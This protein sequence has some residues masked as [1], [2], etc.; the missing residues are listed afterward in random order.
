MDAQ[1]AV[2]P[3]D[4]TL[5]AHGSGRL[6]DASAE[7]VGRHLASCPDCRRRVAA[8]SA[9]RGLGRPSDAGARTESRPAGSST[10]EPS[11]LDGLAAPAVTPA[12][13]TLPPGLADHPNYE[14]IRELGRGGMGVVYL[15]QNR[16]MGRLEVLKVVGGHLVSR[17][18]V[19]ERFLREIRS[20]AR[21]HHPNIVTAYAALR[22]GESLVLAMEYVE[23]LDL[24]RIV[25]ARGPLP[26][27]NACHYAHQAALG[28]QHAHEHG[29]V[30]RDI[31][32]ANLILARAG[33][34]GNKAAVKVLDFG[35]AK[36]TSEGDADSGLTREGQMLGTPDYIAPEQIRD[37]QSADIRADIYS[38]GCTLY[39]LLAGK[40]PFTGSSL[41]D[42][43]Q[44]HFSM[45]ASPL[46]LVRPDVPAELAAVVAKMLAKEPERRFQEPRE[47]AQALSPFFKPAV[48]SGTAPRV[49]TTAEASPPIAAG[50]SPSRTEA[51]PAPWVSVVTVEDGAS[52]G[53]RTPGP[54]PAPAARPARRPPWFWPAAVAGALL[55]GLAAML[56][57]LTLRVRT[58]VGDLVI[59]GLPD[60]ARVTVDGRACTLEWPGGKGPARASVAAGDHRVKVELDGMEVLADEV[61]IAA[62]QETPITVRL[63]PVATTGRSPAAPKAAGPA[64]P[65][66]PAPSLV[67][68]TADNPIRKAWRVGGDWTIDG[69]E[70]VQSD[71]SKAAEIAFGDMNWSDY[72]L[73]LDVK[74]VKGDGHGIHVMFHR[75]N[76]VTF[77]WFGLGVF[78]NKGSELYFQVDRNNRSRGGELRSDNWSGRTIDPGRWYPVRI[79]VRK[80]KVECYLDGDLIFQDSRSAFKYGR[81]G[82]RTGRMQARFRRIKVT[83]PDGRVL[84]EGLPDVA[85]PTDAFEGFAGGSPAGGGRADLRPL[86]DEPVVAPPTALSWRPEPGFTAL[87]NGRDWNGWTGFVNANT[88]KDEP[89][90]I[91]RLLDGE[92]LMLPG[93]RGTGLRTDRTHRDF[94]LKLEYLFPVGGNLTPP[95]SGILIMPESAG[96]LSFQQAF[97]CEIRT[98]EAGDLWATAGAS[99]VGQER[100]G[101][102]GKVPRKLDNER[103]PGEWNAVVIKCEGSR[104]TF[105]LNGREVNRAESPRPISA[106]ISLI[107]QGSDIRFRHI[108]IRESPSAAIVP[109]GS[110]ARAD[111]PRPVVG[112]WRHASGA[113]NANNGGI[114]QIAPNGSI[115]NARGAQ[116]GT[117]SLSGSTLLLRWP[118]KLAPGGAWI[119]RVQLS[120]D[121]RRYDGKNQ[122]GVAIH[123]LR[124]EE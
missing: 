43:Y 70:L 54:A 105:E 44:A 18:A 98:G 31:K 71:D 90:H 50:R 37:A 21:L 32:P 88:T 72:D 75:L 47:V 26:L 3:T 96:G 64:A 59:S 77:C 29:M 121:R 110:P 66:R 122:R 89:A 74:K 60:G 73:A 80:S 46:N 104:I 101:P 24:A 58:E 123:G 84:F 52:I 2:H 92:I 69:D 4:Q 7:A 14:V 1:P 118:N 91:A 94:T 30:H 82:L 106:W 45:D 40:A 83:A 81:I 65:A 116:T 76:Q 61:R 117:W 115:L 67:A 22:L 124:V 111:Q 86:P 34:R 108:E 85:A 62:G 103:P 87:F 57:L 12:A 8:L 27:A 55:L 113:P 13:N 114:I 51:D 23:G 6:D 53:S 5:L 107:N 56:A 93:K 48:P 41:W 20:A 16:L 63:E 9:D 112:K 97:E 120:P 33:G 28:L 102:R 38:L 42:L 119:D 25:K 15:A 35:L 17:P 79:R 36:V 95:G 100:H 109:S 11:L 19:L 49:A 10:D 68:S 78:Q 99:L 39:Y